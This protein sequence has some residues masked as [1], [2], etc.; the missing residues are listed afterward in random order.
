MDFTKSATALAAV[1]ISAGFAPNAAPASAAQP[2]TQSG[3]SNMQNRGSPA[4]ANVIVSLADFTAA[5]RADRTVKTERVTFKN[6]AINM[7]GILFSPANA[8]PGRTYP[9]VVVIHPAGGIKEQTASLYAYRLAQNG[10][11]ALAYDASHQGESGGEPRLLEDP[12][13]RVETSEA[14]STT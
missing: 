1:F 6:G 14:R 3:G 4:N 7:A 11:V 12:T 10:Y 5:V 8:V 13:A 2:A 9:A